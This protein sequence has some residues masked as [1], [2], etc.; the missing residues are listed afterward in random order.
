MEELAILKEYIEAEDY[1][2]ALQLIDE[3]QAMSKEDK[4]QKI[5]SYLIIILVHLIKQ[6]AEQRTTRSWNFSIRNA[7]REIKYVNKRGKSGGY[8]ASEAELKELIEEAYCTAIDKA[9]LEAFE[10][11]YT[12]VQLEDMIDVAQV[13]AQAFEQI[14]GDNE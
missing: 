8:Y 3:L 5:R 7:A 10:G 6:S 2:E 1:E 4:L 13:K 12:E 9:S 11:I 14:K